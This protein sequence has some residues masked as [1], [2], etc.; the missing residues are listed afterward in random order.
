MNSTTVSA[1]AA[2]S[3]CGGNLKIFSGSSNPAL[4][5]KVAEHL[6]LEVADATIHKFANNETN[7]KIGDSVRGEDVFIIQSGT[8]LEKTNDCVMELFIMI[9]A[10]NTASAGRVTAVIPYFPY[11]KQSKQKRRGTIPAK[12]MASLLKVSGVDQVLTMDL[13]H[14]QMQGFFDIPIDNLKASPI[15][16][17]FIRDT[18][19]NYETSVVVAKNAGASKRAA[20]IAKRLK[21]DFAM[22]F[23]EQTKFAE[24][25]SEETLLGLDGS[26]DAATAEAQSDTFDESGATKAASE[27]ADV[28]VRVDDMA[29]SVHVDLTEDAEE[30]AHGGSVI[31][32]VDGR[33]CLLIDDLI[34]S[35]RP[36]VQAAKLLKQ[37]K[38]TRVTII[39][40]HGMLSGSAA[41]ELQ[42][43]TFV[44]EVIVTNTIPQEQNMKVCSKI[45]VIDCSPVIGE[46]IRRIHNDESL[47]SV[48]GHI[49]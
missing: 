3:H 1:K 12:L 26:L 29:G 32:S 45:R 5:A 17:N 37:H 44:D 11:S 36:F 30:S 6:A 22:I 49:L 38:A 24:C 16:M 18:I 27:G 48:F 41:A 33:P 4:S 2:R 31:G 19:P 7:V 15:V 9:N 39:A 21:L 10:L 43:C 47:A 25:L 13:H 46:C 34:D 20:L 40:T 28:D 14:M 23:G 35:A 42:A 8:G